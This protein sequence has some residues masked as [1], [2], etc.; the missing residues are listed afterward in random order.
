MHLELV[1]AD[2]HLVTRVAGLAFYLDEVDEE[3][4]KVLGFDDV[5]CPV[6]GRRLLLQALDRHGFRD[7]RGKGRSHSP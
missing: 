5:I 2:L 4:L 1:S 7:T 6:L 3:F